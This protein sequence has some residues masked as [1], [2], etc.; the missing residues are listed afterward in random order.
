LHYINTVVKL[1]LGIIFVHFRVIEIHINLW[2]KEISA[3]ISNILDVIDI[4]L[5]LVLLHFV[6]VLWLCWKYLF[7]SN[8]SLFSL[9]LWSSSQTTIL[10]S[11][12]RTI[13]TLRWIYFVLCIIPFHSGRIRL[14]SDAPSGSTQIILCF[15]KII[16]FL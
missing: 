6:A 10:Q 11:P 4:R 7:S 8:W 3:W 5:I 13:E 9:Y 14:S 1:S 12:C 2:V 15:W 16:Y